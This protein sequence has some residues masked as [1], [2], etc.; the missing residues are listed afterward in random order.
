MECDLAANMLMSH[1]SII[2]A[3]YAAGVADHVLEQSFI[4][5]ASTLI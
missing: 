2:G 5:A 1:C 3:A 4:L